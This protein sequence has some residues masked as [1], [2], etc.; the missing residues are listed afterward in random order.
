MLH[1]MYETHNVCTCGI[2][3]QN[4]DKLLTMGIQFHMQA[5]NNPDTEIYVLNL[6]S[7]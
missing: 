7:F 1:I 4:A 6:N 2:Y 3:I 5:H